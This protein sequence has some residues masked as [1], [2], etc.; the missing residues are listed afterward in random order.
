MKRM[1]KLLAQYE[2]L[3]PSLQTIH[4]YLEQ[5]RRWLRSLPASE[6]GAGLL[7][8]TEYLALQTDALEVCA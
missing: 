1:A 6:G 3:S 5:A 7:G 4:Q 8:L 2:T